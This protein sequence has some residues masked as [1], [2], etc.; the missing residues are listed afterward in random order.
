VKRR[1][2][3][4]LLNGKAISLSRVPAWLKP[5]WDRSDDKHPFISKFEINPDAVAVIRS[6]FEMKQQKMGTYTIVRKLNAS[7]GWTPPPTRGRKGG[8]QGWRACTVKKYLRWTA[9]LGECRPTTVSKDEGGR[10]FVPAGNP[11]SVFPQIIDKELFHAVQRVMDGRKH[12]GGRPGRHGYS[13]HYNVLRYLV[14]CPYCSGVMDYI[15]RKLPH[16]KPRLECDRGRRAMK[17]SPVCGQAK[18]DYAEVEALIL[19]NCPK[20]RPAD[21]LPDPQ[22]SAK[23][24]LA[25]R[26]RLSGLEGQIHDLERRINN[27]VDQISET[28]DKDNRNLFELKV[29]QFREQ[30]A[31]LEKDRVAVRRELDDAEKDEATFANWQR[32]LETLRTQMRDDAGV[33]QRLNGHLD[34]FIDRIEVFAVGHLHKYDPDRP[35][36]EREPC[37]KGRPKRKSGQE[38][39]KHFLHQHQEDGETL[40]QSVYEDVLEEN[41]KLARDQQFV[42]FLEDLS[43]RRM[44]PEGRFVRVHFK[45]G[46]RVDLVPEGS[47][48]YGMRV[49]RN[50]N[51][52]EPVR[53]DV[54]ALWKAHR[55]NQTT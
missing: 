48:A 4:E 7:A 9:V 36:P 6:M 19:E 25:L 37:E 53:P 8:G 54:K 32:D 17:P 18:I 45:T 41:P 16:T 29:S 51:G 3:E 35:R 46:A 38:A 33:R 14:K 1:K 12:R 52:W 22:E 27:L 44:S 21:V 42:A 55:E 20:L 11:V 43:K 31:A 47:L 26:Q 13:G 34:E 2:R 10:R 40:A 5:V 24:V 30:K 28:D 15:D 39:M 49:D 50:G 23:R